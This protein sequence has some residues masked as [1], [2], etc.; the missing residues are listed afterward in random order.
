MRMLEKD[1]L[2]TNVA[3]TPDMD[4]WWEGMDGSP[5]ETLTDWRGHP[6]K[7]GSAE[8]A[9]HPN[10]R[11]TAPASNNPALSSK[12][13]DPAGVPISAIIFGGRRSTTVPLVLEAFNW[14]HGVFMG[15]TMGSET[16]AAAVGLKEGVR[17][18]PMA[19]LPFIGYDAGTYLNHWLEMQGKIP[20]PPKV[21]MV[22][23]FRKDGNGKFMWPGYG[24]N[25]RVLKWIL[26][27]SHGRVTAKETLVGNVPRPEDINLSGVDLTPEA[28][29]KVMDVDLAEWET[30]LE[31]Q[32]EWFEKLGKTLPKPIALQRDILLERV[33]AA[34]RAG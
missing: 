34:R 23:W 7:R 3:L 33:R 25:M 10:S 1:T 15:A 31:S 4:V 5:P 28:A 11:F 16:T 27:R 29:R 13:D 9:A 2:F 6:W 17:R 8:K 30:E 12:V 21:F 14:T 22:N 26:D 32:Q 19:M 20:N 24:D 18:D